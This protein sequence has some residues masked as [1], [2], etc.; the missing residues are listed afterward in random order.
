MKPPTMSLARPIGRRLTLAAA[1][2]S[3]VGGAACN[4]NDLLTVATPDVVLPSDL[5]S[6]SALPNAY[7]ATIG[8]FALG[9]AGSSRANEEGLVNMSGLLSDEFY[10]AETFPTRVEVDMRRTNPIN[11][12][13]LVLFQNLQR[14]RATAELVSSRFAN[15]DPLNPL[16]VEVQALEAYTYV[17]FAE[18]YCNGVPTSKV[19]DGA[20]VYGD[21]QTNVQMLTV[22]IAK[23]DSAI[24]VATQIGASAN[25]AQYLARVGKAR[26]Q[27][28]LGN[29][30]AAAATVASVP[31]SFVYNIGADENTTRQNNGVY[32]YTFAQKRFSV[33]DNEGGNGLPFISSADPRVAAYRNGGG[34]T[35]SIPYFQTAKYQG[36]PA[37][38]RNAPTPLSLGTE[39]RLI[40]AEAALAA[41]ND[42][43]FLD[44][45]NEA[46]ANSKTYI[47]GNDP[48][49]APPAPLTVLDLGTDATSRQN[50]LFSERAFDL[51]LTA[52]RVGDLRRLIRQYGRG[53]ESVFPT[54]AY[55]QGGTYG[56]DVNLPVPFEEQN[57]SKFKQCLDRAP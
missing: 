39:A 6:A 15:L 24:A 49:P 12:T 37:G 35:A 4:Q 57:N 40:E 30:A 34:F 23:F 26:A 8:D 32:G 25:S 33:A 20:F 51:Y 17:L 14:G 41:A 28:N 38:T 46:R 3:A 44:K 50:L 52:H 54:G 5:S 55:L 45:L 11:G 47:K 13:M 7:A 29:Y 9:Y 10:N 56:T 1:L 19:V 31:T 18:N 53:S 43:T 48:A 27:V 22:A 16:R 42:V 2:L 36:T 21:P